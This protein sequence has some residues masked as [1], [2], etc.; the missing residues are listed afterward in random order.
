M[1]DNQPTNVPA[2]DDTNPADDVSQ[3]PVNGNVADTTVNTDGANSNADVNAQDVDVLGKYFKS[4]GI[5]ADFDNLNEAK[6]IE[7]VDG[8]SKEDFVKIAKHN[9]SLKKAVSKVANDAQNNQI[10][11]AP[12]PEQPIVNSSNSS[13]VEPPVQPQPVQ[14]PADLDMRDALLLRGAVKE[15]YPEL[16][17]VVADN[18][19]FK[20]AKEEGVQFKS[21]S[22]DINLTGIMKF[23]ERENELAVL[24][25]KVADFEKNKA[26]NAPT[27]DAT[28][29]MLQDS[30]TKM[31]M[32]LAEQLLYMP[33]HERHQEAKEFITNNNPLVKK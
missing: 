9:I 19:L 25:K 21:P 10:P 8:L 31:T 24:K 29:Q 1:A 2:V 3:Q 30:N 18:T 27:V 28:Q 22:G 7:L 26:A 20:K 5:Q 12:A 16:A 13:Q 23:A 17:D 15:A 6:L 4:Q 11:N 32:D 33:N 14:A